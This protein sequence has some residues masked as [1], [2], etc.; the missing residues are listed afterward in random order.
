MVL[1]NFQI[2]FDNP[3]NTF[4]GGQTVTGRVLVVIDSTK[5]I[6]GINIRIKGEANTAWTESKSELNNDGKYND[7]N[8]MVT[9]HEQYFNI[10]YY[11]LGGASGVEIQLPPGEHTYPFSCV[12]PPNLPSSFES[13]LG[14]VR[15]TVKATLDRPWKFDQEVKTAFTVISPLDLN[16]ERG[17]AEP[18][19]EEL[20]KTFCCL[21]CGSAPLNVNVI[22]PVRGYVPGQVI[23][24]RVNVE[25]LSNVTV[26]TVKFVLRKVVTF[27]ASLPSHATKK[28]KIVVSEIGKGP[29]EANATVHWEERLT[30]PPLPPSNLANCGIIKLEYCIKVE[31]C[32]SGWYHR[33]LK[34]NIPVY[35]GTV[36]LTSYQPPIALPP[37]NGLKPDEYSAKPADPTYGGYPSG[38][39]AF[40]PSATAPAATA[41]G[42]MV[43][44]QPGFT[45][46]VV[47]PP[48]PPAMDMYPNLPPPSY[49]ESRYGARS[50]RER[51]ESE[52]VLGA[53]NQ[54]APR[55]PVYNFAQ[56]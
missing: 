6:R 7:E 24:I 21:C 40:N 16:Q 43:P 13:D 52:H 51:G 28:V 42:F 14:H 45:M 3:W 26:D 56:E 53:R 47:P 4:Y 35:V 12:L 36:P 41:P 39:P 10:Q 49:A 22:L 20:T 25:N 37:G 5:K 11:L 44:D 1:R 31:A 9:G 2:L 46:P 18:V 19:N 17:A 23:P 34:K 38:Y 29:V 50:I 32:V 30:V 55:Y 33:N 27:T 48:L 8:Q 54:F 15:Y